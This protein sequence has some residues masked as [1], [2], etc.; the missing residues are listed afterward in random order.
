MKRVLIIFLLFIVVN[1]AHANTCREVV[2]YYAGWK[3]YKRNKLVN[4]QTIDYSRY[5]IIN[6]AFFKPLENGSVSEGD[7]WADKNILLGN[8]VTRNG[9]VTYD[10]SSSLVLNAHQHGV[11]VFGSIG[12][13]TYSSVFPAIAAD[14]LKRKKFADACANLVLKYDLDGIDIDWEYPGFKTHNGSAADTR[15]FTLLLS[16]IRQA[17]N[18]QG[19]SSGKKYLL[20]AAFSPSPDHMK[21]I[22]WD[23][24]SELVDII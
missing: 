19:N 6:Y 7:E 23:K 20:T 14:P 24:V 11:K 9:V 16:E 22:E 12:G 5:T 15:N 2:G 10:R 18:D 4:P 13:W 17:L 1:P 3:W 8:V 21:A